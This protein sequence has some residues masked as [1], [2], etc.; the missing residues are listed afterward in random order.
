M[1]WRLAVET[2]NRPLPDGVPDLISG[3]EHMILVSILELPLPTMNRLFPIALGVFIVRLANVTACLF[4]IQLDVK[5]CF[6]FA[7]MLFTMFV[8]ILRTIELDS[9]GHWG[10]SWAPCGST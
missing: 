10:P 5:M 7:A 9:G 6:S 2:E 1:E 3:F 8:F 4:M